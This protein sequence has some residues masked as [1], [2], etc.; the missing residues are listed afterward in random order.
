MNISFIPIRYATALYK[1]VQE[2]GN[3]KEI[4]RQVLALSKILTGNKSIKSMLANPVADKKAK[5]EILFSLLKQKINPDLK[6]FIV[7]LFDRQREIY[8]NEIL[9]RYVV[10]FREKNNIHFG[11]LLTAS[12]LDKETEVKIVSVMS[13]KINGALE[14][15][16]ATD[17]TLTGG[18][19]LEV[20]NVRCDASIK[21]KLQ[22]IKKELTG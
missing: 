13:R 18:F 2:H 6:K 20:D 7:F 21:G 17:N 22:K 12:E 15:E 5:Q 1:Y 19:I 4:Y 16:S 11:K 3:D 10:L 8:I 14:I 9:C